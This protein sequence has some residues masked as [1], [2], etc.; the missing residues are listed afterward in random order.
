MKEREM[1]QKLKHHEVSAE[2]VDDEH[3]PAIMLTQQDGWGDEPQTTIV[4]PWQLRSIC[5][6]FDLLPASSPDAQRQLQTMARRL[7]R[8]RDRI[9][10]LRDHIANHSDHRHAD[11]TLELVSVNALAD[12][13][14]E[15][16]E[17]LEPI[18]E[19]FEEAF[20]EA[21]EAGDDGSPDQP[22]LL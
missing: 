3:G 9:S 11:L 7:R 16:C 5:E 8:L 12:L 19:D 20:R 14:D 4:H 13:A 1:H 10:D 2:W 15:W 22:S 21:S 18:G 17:D 6:H